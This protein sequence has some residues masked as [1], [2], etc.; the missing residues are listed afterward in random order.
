[1][2]GLN[3]AVTVAQVTSPTAYAL[4][5]ELQRLEIIREVSGAQRGRI[6]VFEDYLHLF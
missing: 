3:S 1:M 6:Y 2:P 4:L 5:N